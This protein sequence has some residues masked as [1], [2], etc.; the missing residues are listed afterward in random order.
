V[1]TWPGPAEYCSKGIG[2]E[3]C[4]SKLKN[5]NRFLA[6]IILPTLTGLPLKG[7]GQALY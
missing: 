3:H 7:Y 1:Q 6:H 4:P 2:S 5:I